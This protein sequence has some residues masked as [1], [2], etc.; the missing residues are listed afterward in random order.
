MGAIAVW[1]STGLTDPAAQ[2][3]MSLE[4][5][6]QLFNGAGLTIGEVTARAK[7]STDNTDVKRTWVLLGDPATKLR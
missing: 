7:G 2:V 6:R 3:I 5:V 1:A 4:A